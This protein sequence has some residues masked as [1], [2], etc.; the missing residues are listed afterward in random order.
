MRP[1]HDPFGARGPFSGREFD[2]EFAGG[3]IRRLSTGR[4]RVT[5][6][7]L[8]VVTRRLER[9]GPD[10]PNEGMLQRLRDVVDGTLRPTSFDMNFYTHE[11]REFVRY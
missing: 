9:F 4:V 8:D 6:R 5:E 10:D 11:L 3:P 2:L 7:G 1:N